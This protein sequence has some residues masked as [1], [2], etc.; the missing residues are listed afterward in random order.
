MITSI[1]TYDEEAVS[2]EEG[3][4]FEE[5]ET[6]TRANHMQNLV[7]EKG[8]SIEYPDTFDGQH[9]DPPSRLPDASSNAEVL[10]TGVH[11]P[12]VGRR[13]RLP[14]RVFPGAFREG[15]LDSEQEDEEDERT[16]QSHIEPPIP[17]TVSGE[18]F[19][20]KE[21]ER[22]RQDD[23]NKAIQEVQDQ[24]NQALARERQQAVV[25]EV[26]PEYDRRWKF[27]GAFLLLALIIVGVVLGITLRPDKDTETFISQDLIDMLSNASSDSGEALITPLTPQNKALKWLAN[28]TNLATYTEQEK[29][30]R[31]ALATLYY[32]TKGESWTRS[33][34]WL[35]SAD[36]CDKWYQYGFMTIDCTSAGAVV[37]LLLVDNNLIGKIPAEIGML[38]DSLGELIVEGRM[39]LPILLARQIVPYYPSRV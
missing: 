38:S 14:Q 21:E 5:K 28:N 25:A 29:I 22:R 39:I 35:S 8:I 16:I 1:W 15:G 32:S 20:A 30:Q 10:G 3:D 2:M 18:L 13:T 33:D 6:I 31:Y 17:P 34:R 4:P 26:I 36:V 12:T 27:A 37:H 19:D 7:A 11:H 24:I 9:V 23:I